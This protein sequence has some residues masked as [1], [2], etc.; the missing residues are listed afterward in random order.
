LLSNVGFVE[1]TAT[2]RAGVRQ[3]CLVDLVDLIGARRLAVGLGAIVPS[4]LERRGAIRLRT[5]DTILSRHRQDEVA[6]NVP[7]TVPVLKRGP[8]FVLDAVLE[9]EIVSL[10]FDGLKRVDGPSKL[11][12]FHYFPVLFHEGQ[13]IR[14]E[15]KR[16]LEVYGLFLSQVQGKTPAWGVIWHGKECKATK[17]RLSIEPRTTQQILRDLQQLLAGEPPRLLLNDHCQVCEFRRRCHEQAVR[18]DSLSLLR[19]L[20][21]KESRGTPAE[22]FSP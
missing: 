3:A 11:G 18:E 22:A 4:A 8:L 9:D 12:D 5:T 17:V 16:L 15:Q 14:K 6:R 20:G 1:K 2:L 10:L 19:G 21:E 7:L 13:A